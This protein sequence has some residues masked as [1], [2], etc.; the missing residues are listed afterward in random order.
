M[1][2]S[3]ATLASELEAL[4]PEATEAAAAARLTEA[5][6]NY[7]ADAEGNAV[8][9]ESTGIDLGKAAM[10]PALAGMSAPG[11]GAT[12]IANAVI[13]FWVAAAVPASFPTAT[14]VV[15]PPNAGLAVALEAVFASNTA[16][17]ASLEDAAANIAAVMHAQAIIGGT[18]TLPGPSVGPIL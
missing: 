6:G 1:A 11:A 5:Y 8:P 13:A 14:I 16:A 12:V 10:E 2:M 3:E 18:V 7:A 15:P 4:V 17:Q 9:I